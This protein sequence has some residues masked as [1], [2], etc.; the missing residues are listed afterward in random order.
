M[1]DDA[2]GFGLD[3]LFFG[4][5]NTMKILA[6]HEL[7][8]WDSFVAAH[9][10]GSMYHTTNMIRSL[11]A[12]RNNEPFA[13]AVV[14]CHGSICAMLVATRVTTV[15]G[16]GMPLAARSIMYAEPLHLPT[17]AGCSGLRQLL[18]F[19]DQHMGHRT[20]F[21]EVRP[22]FAAGPIDSAMREAGYAKQ[23]YLNY[24]IA[25]QP[26]LDELF[27]SLG[28]KRRNNIRA[29]ERRG[30]EFRL[31]TSRQD[32]ED[33]YRLICA[34]YTRSKV[35]VAEFALFESAFACL[36]QEN[37]RIFTAWYE[38]QPVAT[39]AFLGFKGR[40]TCWYAGTLRVPGV[41]AMT[42]VFW[43]AMQFFAQEGYQV[44]DLAGGGWEGE[45]YG[46]GKFKAKFG[47]Q[48]TNFGRYRKVYSPWKLSVAS[49]VYDRVR[50]FMTPR[51]PVSFNGK[52]R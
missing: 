27:Q 34:S 9:P 49:A 12:T 43:H 10:Q 40:V 1:S 42:A 29:A 51:V 38:S 23:G 32:L 8:E 11:E 33:F 5:A 26:N 45:A 50:S 13:Y 35:P 52:H 48:E 28:G 17:H 31:G 47:G 7:P 4:H 19:H 16:L 37:L 20:L 24:E 41:P 3:L 36:P 46:P 22:V 39:G 21:C 18:A 2:D 25:L 6:H 15:R 44:F 30:V 14:D